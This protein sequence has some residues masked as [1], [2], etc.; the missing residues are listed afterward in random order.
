MPLLGNQEFTLPVETAVPIIDPA[1]CSGVRCETG[2]VSGNVMWYIK[3][4]L[5]LIFNT[6]LFGKQGTY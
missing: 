1:N 2:S 6:I 5:A 3:L 4:Y